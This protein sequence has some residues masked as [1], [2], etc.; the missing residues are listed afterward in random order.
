MTA[1]LL[2]S[3]DPLP[4]PLHRLSGAFRTTATGAARYDGL[5]DIF[6]ESYWSR[7]TV[8]R[9]V[10]LRCR[11]HTPARLRLIRRFVEARSETHSPEETVLCDLVCTN[12]EAVLTTPLTTPDAPDSLL[13][14]EVSGD[15]TVT[16]QEL[17][18]DAVWETEE[19]PVRAVRLGL[20]ITTFNRE[21]FL[22]A[23]LTQ[24]R[25][26]MAGGCAI[27]VNHGA[28]G[29]EARLRDRLVPDPAIRWIDQENR[30]GA[31]GFTR[32]IC[33]H[34]RAGDVSHVLLMDDDI[35]LPADLVER[36]HAILSYSRPDI[37][38]GGAMFDYHHRTRLFSAGDM[39]VPGSFAISHIAPPGGCDIST[40][41][42]VDF[43]ARVHR[44]DFN[45]WWCFAFPIEAIDTVGLPMPCFIRGDDVEFGYRLKRAGM[46]TLGWPGLAVWHMPFADKSAPWH[47]FYD[48]RN[49]LFTNAR[50]QRVGRMAAIA[51]LVGGFTHQLLRYDY[52]R[53]RA[54]TLGI[55]AFNRGAGAMARWTHHDHAAL[56]AATSAMLAP[57]LR[58]WPRNAAEGHEAGPGDVRATDSPRLSGPGR[59]L[60][61]TA[62]LAWD[63]AGMP[64][65]KAVPYV[66][67]PGTAWRPD[68]AHRPA[69][70]VERNGLGEPVR[71]FRRDPAESRR[72]TW[73]FVRALAGM[74]LRFNQHTDASRVPRTSRAP[75]IASSPLKL[76]E[77]SGD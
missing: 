24:L 73:R 43:L 39:L 6:P 65:G 4:V 2:P 37:C 55:A 5:F 46:P 20:A 52:D 56:L 57:D 10:S 38:L 1:T 21:A 12:G 11:L 66:L 3:A 26:R 77:F 44:P 48:R 7:F 72:A 41:Q 40:P 70:A 33:E 15:G 8:L 19:P 54:M 28:P 18:Y 53:V 62:R 22:V 51:K 9:R 58:D 60:R 75:K 27:I 25:G 30:G 45:G 23:N 16:Q 29:L 49:G 32:G 71:I 76:A 63:L 61:M 34:R 13:L 68:L 69:V 36:T 59:S 47:M 64:A 74:T 31:G 35:N 67:S 17:L 14:L 50:H 42:G